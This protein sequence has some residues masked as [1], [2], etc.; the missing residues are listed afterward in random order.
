ME[1][2]GAAKMAMRSLLHKSKLER[3]G[4]WLESRGWTLQEPKGF[5][6]VLRATANGKHTLVVWRRLELIEHYTVSDKW[7]VL[8]R[9]FIKNEREDS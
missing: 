6:E 2:K 9:E 4:K 1:T 5:Y 7:A 8:V 3:F